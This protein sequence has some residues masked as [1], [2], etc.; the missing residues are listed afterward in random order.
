M[1]GTC[2]K[3][4]GRYFLRFYPK[5]STMHTFNCPDCGA[6]QTVKVQG[7]TEHL[8]LFFLPDSISAIDKMKKVYNYKEPVKIKKEKFPDLEEEYEQDC[9]SSVKHYYDPEEGERLHSSYY[10]QRTSCLKW[11][12]KLLDTRFKIASFNKSHLNQLK[13]EK[14]IN[15]QRDD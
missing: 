14:S 9:T 4:Q 15:Y 8:A 13:S 12:D 5:R 6:K 7:E 2:S 10:P 11:W 1:I 3:C